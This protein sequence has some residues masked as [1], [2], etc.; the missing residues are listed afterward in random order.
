MGTKQNFSRRNF[1]KTGTA[2][3][4]LAAVGSFQGSMSH[5]EPAAEKQAEEKPLKYYPVTHAAIRPV[6]HPRLGIEVDG[7]TAV[8]YLRFLRHTRIDRLEIGR[9]VYGRWI[10][11]VP[12]HPAHIIVSTLN[13]TTRKWE[14]IREVDLPEEPEIRGEGLSQE[15]SAEEMDAHFDR[16]LQK[17]PHRIEL[18]GIVA[19]LLRVECDR[20]HPAWP[21]HGECNGGIFNVPF[22]ALN[23]LRAYGEFT[24]PEPPWPS[25]TPILKTA[26]FSPK[27]PDGMQVCDLPEMLLFE[28]KHMSIGF[29]LRRPM[30][31]HLGWDILGEGQ[32]ANNRLLIAK[33]GPREHA[34]YG[35][36]LSGPIL[37]T[38]GQDYGAHRWTGEVSVQ[39]NRVSYRN[40]HAIPGVTVDAIFIVEANRLLIELSQT[41]E[42]DMPLLEAEAWR[43]NW[44]LQAGITGAAAMP[45]LEPGRNGD[46]RLPFQWATDGVGCLSCRMPEQDG[47]ARVQVESYRNSRVVT[48]GFV[49]AKHPAPDECLC[50]P[51]GTQK[52]TFEF[53]LSNLEPDF[54]EG[55]PKPS[56]GIQRHWA[57][58]FSC[59]RPEYRGFSNHSAS[60]NCHLSQ[61]PPIEIAAH[62]R[63][64]ADIPDPLDLARYT[65]GR[66]FKD[67]GGYGYCRNLYLDSDPILVSAAGRIHQAEP[68]LSWLHEIEPGLLET[69]RRM[70]Q[71]IGTEGLLVCRDLSGN[72]GS[73]RWSTNSMDVI[74]FGHIDAY[75]NAWA[76]RAFRNAAAMMTDLKQQDLAKRCKDLADGIQSVY[77]ER[78]IN[79]ETGWVAG[80]RSRDEELHDAAYTWVN[81][82]ALAFG[83]LEPT[84]ARKAMEKMEA[85]RDCV[86][87]PSYRVG[88]PCNLLPIKETDHM[89]PRIVS[90]VEPTFERYT[91]GS[92]SG[93]PATYYLRALSVCGLKDRARKLA[94]ELNE[95][96]ET[97][98]FNGGMGEGH[99]FRSWEGIPNG[100]EGTLIGVFGPMYAIAIEQGLIKPRDPEW[101]PAG[102]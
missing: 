78:L 91:D 51:A 28:G 98:I 27:A 90:I 40:L 32:A 43:L 11:K 53:A 45:T 31:Y 60:V 83:V 99:E 66:A 86:G 17:P 54:A 49:F 19:E 96:F 68:N 1:V 88:L 58:V 5:A 70:E 14:T 36:G 73:Y 93:W 57:T 52:A 76:Y 80:W 13:E 63:R 29:S 77:A 65:I 24:G 55:S 75:V 30:L 74:G 37:R 67:G 41:C 87:P 97:G 69:I 89:L 23:E 22:G 72:S 10:P 4:T 35:N 48:G 7:Q 94:D 71:E 46:I 44:D 85:L 38:F 15:M 26:E 61:G 12:V 25:Y 92:L 79:P 18:D 2:A 50:L 95:G 33:T 62:T 81:G 56:A 34:F 84:I 16:V 21:N 82:A 101:W 47:E 8:R 64:Q 20:E 102:G 59:F 6:Q 42:K 39:G 9:I 100:Y 3:A